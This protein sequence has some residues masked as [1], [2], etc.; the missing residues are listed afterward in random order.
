MIFYEDIAVLPL[1]DDLG[2]GK[3]LDGVVH[4]DT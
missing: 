1:F 4:I 3:C 2:V